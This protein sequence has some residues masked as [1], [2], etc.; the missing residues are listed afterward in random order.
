MDTKII[1]GDLADPRVIQLLQTHLTKCRAETAVG[2]AHALDLSGL[3]LPEVKF[4]TLWEGETLL[5]MGAVKIIEPKHCEVKSMHT[6]E[7]C[8]GKGLASVLLKHLIQVAKDLGAERLSLETGSWEY[9]HP[10]RELYRK[11]GF[12]ECGPFGDYLSDPNSVFMTLNL[13]S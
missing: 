5:G 6:V 11:H 1:E 3:K 10:A 13:L 7:A 2:S 8:R 9:F 4:F 12:V